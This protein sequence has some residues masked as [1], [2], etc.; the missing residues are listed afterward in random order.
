MLK[1]KYC[2]EDG[3]LLSKIPSFRQFS[4]YFQKTATKENLI[5]SR[6]GKGKFLRNHRVMLG[7]GI[8]DFCP[9]IGYGMF[10]STICDIFLVNDKGEL[11]GRPIW[12]HEFASDSLHKEIREKCKPM[13]IEMIKGEE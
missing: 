8:R 9:S 4:Y 13:I 11:L 5:I 1:D 2:D 10:D 3:K 6:E 7:N 12:T